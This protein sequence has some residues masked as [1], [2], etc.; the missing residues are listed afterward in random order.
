[1]TE[2]VTAS[3]PDGVD[4]YVITYDEEGNEVRLLPRDV[5]D[6]VL[7]RSQHLSIGKGRREI[8]RVKH[9]PLVAAASELGTA[10]VGSLGR[11]L[12]A[13]AYGTTLIVDRAAPPLDEDVLDIDER[14]HLDLLADV[15]VAVIAERY[16]TQ[17]QQ[18][19]QE[20]GATLAPVAAAYNC[21]IVDVSFAL[22]DGSTPEEALA[23]WPADEE[24][25]TPFR[26]QTFESL[27]G[28]AH[29][30]IVRVTTENAMTVATLTDG[31]AAIA[32]FLK[33][34]RGGALNAA[35]VLNLLRGGHFGALFGRTESAYLEVKTAMHPIW[36]DGA[37]GLRAKVELSQ[38]V[39][40]FANGDVDAVLVIGYR[41]ADRGRGEIGSLTPVD[42]RHLDTAQIREVLDARIVPP[43]D[44]LIIEKFDASPTGSVLA[45]Y[46]PKQPAEMQPY[47]VQGAIVGDKLEG[48]FF[49]IV[50][51][52]G[53]GSITTSAQQI[54]AYIVAGKRYLRGT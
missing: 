35:G 11:A 23:D 26:D 19:P 54:H 24:W 52:R 39:A 47:L 6:D 12:A 37:A 33:A 53:E 15:L 32:D 20:F 21:R 3:Q 16:A 45:V 36:A 27:K 4:V 9:G 48:A 42:D 40:R 25:A 13:N 17:P 41:E 7:D 5:P 10:N 44:G 29:D 31:A 38:D 46:V 49:S 50:R 1:M 28:S 18:T 51:R 14:Y 2:P 8:R 43:V 34:T 22:P 30:V